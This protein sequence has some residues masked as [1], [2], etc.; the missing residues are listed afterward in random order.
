MLDRIKRTALVFLWAA[1]WP[2][3]CLHGQS[4]IQRLN[5][6]WP[7]GKAGHYD[8]QFTETVD[9]RNIKTKGRLVF[10]LKQR[11]VTAGFDGKRFDS[12][13]S[14]DST[15]TA[16]LISDD[17]YFLTCEHCVRH[18]KTIKLTLGEITL[19]AKVVDADAN[20]DLALLKVDAEKL[21]ETIK[22]LQ[23][24]AGRPVRLAQDVRAIGYPLSDLLGSN[25]KIVRGGIAGFIGGKPG[26]PT[27]VDSYQIDA[28]V[29]PGN[30]GGPLVDQAG[31]VIGVVNAKS[32]SDRVE[33][34]GF[35]IP[36]RLAVQLLGRNKVKFSTS[37]KAVVVPGPELADQVVPAVAFV[38]VKANPFL[39]D[40]LLFS[41][42][43]LWLRDGV[44]KN[45]KGRI[46]VSKNGSVIDHEKMPWLS[47]MLQPVGN[48]LFVE[49]P[50]FRL[51]KWKD[52]S[53]F[54]LE[55][56][57]RE[58]DFGGGRFGSGADPFGMGRC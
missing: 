19:D 30:S 56:P 32:Q 35:A 16:F 13:G 55:L 46:I 14:Q 45:I 5:F 57:G 37:E 1:V 20:H 8:I 7:V 41:C 38:E 21:P 9:G 17:G 40:N 39:T 51:P 54:S 15:S 26:D 2:A 23:V 31:N 58:D 33:K 10:E 42:T 3:S 52:A 36:A 12:V 28:A 11:N 29:N 50:E 43:G 18:A 34:V 44:P 24:S 47:S 4:S 25:V 53:V 27:S 22:P 49:L 6:D 48:L